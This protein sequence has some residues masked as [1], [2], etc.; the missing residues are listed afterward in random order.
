MIPAVRAFN[1]RLRS[2]GLNMQFYESCLPHGLAKGPETS[3][4][5]E[6][7]VAL[8]QHNVVRGAYGLKHQDFWIGDHTV[9]IADFWLPISEGAVDRNYAFVAAALLLDALQ[10]QPLLYGLGMGG[11][12]EALVRLLKAAGW[13]M[14]SVPFFFRV[15]HTAPFLR[16]LTFVRRRP[17]TRWASTPWPSPGWEG[18]AYA[19][20]KCCHRRVPAPANV[21]LEVVDDFSSWVDE[22]WEQCKGQYGLSSVRTA[23]TMR[24][25]Y[26]NSEPRFIRLKFS[27]DSRPVGL[28]VL[29]DTMLS[30]H[31]QFGNMR[32]GS[33]VNCFGS[34]AYAA[35]IVDLARDFLEA[36]GVD[37]IVSN[38]SHA[39]WRQAFRQSGFLGGPSN[40]IFATSPQLTKLLQTGSVQQAD[41]HLNRGDGDGPMNL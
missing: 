37:L 41:I 15:V 11:Y 34:A 3:L 13:T 32:L 19:A 10:R 38:H 17:V 33:L 23:D 27:V 8:D 35:S 7:F 5:E 4:Y 36:R 16:Y 28:A 30:N 26:P 31:R 21:A 24:I 18:W 1:A 25:L 22:L 40:F 6:H 39:M 20:C 2:G 29:L 9:P 14:F 12:D